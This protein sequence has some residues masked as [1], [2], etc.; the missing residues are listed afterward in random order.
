MAQRRDAV[1]AFF[2]HLFVGKR[3]KI[4][5]SNSISNQAVQVG[6]VEFGHVV[7]HIKVQIRGWSWIRR[8]SGAATA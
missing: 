5:T 3:L 6:E 4:R 7:S 8:T 2:T 1:Y